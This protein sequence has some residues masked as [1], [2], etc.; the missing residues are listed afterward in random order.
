MTK[1]RSLLALLS[2][3]GAD[4]GQWPESRMRGRMSLVASTTFRRAWRQER[5]LDRSLAAAGRA[6][7]SQV[8]SD[9]R[10]ERRL[11]A[12]MGVADE[13]AVERQRFGQ[14]TFAGFAAAS[15]C[16]G[17]IAGGM[18]GDVGINSETYASE[19]ARIWE[20]VLEDDVGSDIG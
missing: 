8:P 20:S 7:A 15:L 13:A 10:M 2:V 11:L 3:Y 6:V 5:A 1:D 17:L 19:D 4:F 12:R 9:G 16:L 18:F 14:R